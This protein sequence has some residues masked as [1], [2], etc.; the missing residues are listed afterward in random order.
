[1]MSYLLS[2]HR[3]SQLV[4]GFS[5]EQ[6]AHVT[7]PSS[8]SGSWCSAGET[9]SINKWTD[10]QN[11][12]TDSQ[13]FDSKRRDLGRGAPVRAKS[14][15]S[16]L[17]PCQLHQSGFPESFTW[18]FLVITSFTLPDGKHAWVSIRVTLYFSQPQLT[19]LYN[20]RLSQHRALMN[21]DSLYSTAFFLFEFKSSSQVAA[22]SIHQR[23]LRHHPLKAPFHSLKWSVLKLLEKE[24]EG[25]WLISL[26]K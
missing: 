25:N 24:E 11:Q 2:L 21:R 15:S 18:K 16:L 19:P 26:H 12:H 23:G 8:N 4:R 17:A 20:I 6:E 14:T 10:A 13:S 3:F 22:C 1:M 7:P 9:S 5:H